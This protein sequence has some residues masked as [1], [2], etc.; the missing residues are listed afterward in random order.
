MIS[1]PDLRQLPTE[2]ILSAAANLDQMSSLEIVR[3]I[4]DQDA[5]VADAVRHALPQI[6]RAIDVVSDGGHLGDERSTCTSPSMLSQA[7]CAGG[8]GDLSALRQLRL[9]RLYARHLAR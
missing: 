8:A 6:A 4:N 7:W 5:T 1:E 9:R 3:V 2:Q